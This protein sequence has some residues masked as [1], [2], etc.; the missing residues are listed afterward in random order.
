MDTAIG[1]VIFNPSKSKRLMM[2]YLYVRNLLKD[3]PVYTLELAFNDDPHELKESD[4]VFHVRSKSYMFH[5][6]RMCRVLETR[7]PTQYTKLV[8]MDADLY[9]SNPHWYSRMSEKLESFDVVQGFEVAN[10]MSLD[11]KKPIFRRRSV[12][13][14]KGRIASFVFHPGFVW[15][16]RRDWYTKIGFFDL[17]VSGGGDL[18]SATGWKKQQI[19][20]PVTSSTTSILPAFD[21]FQKIEEPRLSYLE[22][23]DVFHL[24]HGN[25]R[26]RQY[27]ERHIILNKV[28]DV[29]TILTLNNYGMYEWIDPEKYNPLFLKY[30]TSR[31]DDSIKQ[32]EN[33][34]S[35]GGRLY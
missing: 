32:D 1:F 20:R 33:L 5:K 23:I 26:N 11:Y 14:D 13:F 2:N 25:R 27:C 28:N 24:F 22:G 16:F 3:F 21:D 30:F 12:F 19:R 10:W 29:R 34:N 9:F 6:E 8:F 35:Y 15:G 17:A 31:D 4:T 18:L 7:I